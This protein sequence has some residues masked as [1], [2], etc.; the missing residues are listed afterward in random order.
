MNLLLSP[1]RE[2]KPGIR[3]RTL[4]SRVEIGTFSLMV[5]VVFLALSIS[6]LYLAHAN[7]TAT[8]GY[9]IKKLEIEKNT[10]RTEI[11]ILGQQVS[12]AKSLEAIKNSG[13]LEKMERVKQPIFLRTD[14]AKSQETRE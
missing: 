14:L 3:R 1:H 7:R 5:V 13:V 9:A 4:S 11:E 8:R 10:L 12:E 6:L 2:A